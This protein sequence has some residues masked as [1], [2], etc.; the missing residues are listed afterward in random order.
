MDLIAYSFLNI[1]TKELIE[2][3]VDTESYILW[4][5]LESPDYL[6]VY[7]WELDNLDTNQSTYQEFPEELIR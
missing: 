7:N 3:P 2:L 5:L 1:E 6:M 4:Q